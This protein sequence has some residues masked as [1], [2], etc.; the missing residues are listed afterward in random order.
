MKVTVFQDSD[1][2]KT[3]FCVSGHAGYARA[4]KDIVCAAVSVLTENTVNSI[5]ALTEDRPEQF[6]VN[7]KEG[8]LYFRLKQVSRESAL[9]LD[10]M[11]LCL[12]SIAE[13]YGKFL[14]IQFEEE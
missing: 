6:A 11:V 4:G 2:R 13:E 14:E 3:G 9:L 1:G 12:Q 8:F 5:E 10:S 7:E